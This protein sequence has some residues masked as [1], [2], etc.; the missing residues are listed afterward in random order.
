MEPVE[1]LAGGYGLCGGVLKVCVQDGGTSD[2]ELGEAAALEE[3]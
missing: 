3:L 2:E 1:V